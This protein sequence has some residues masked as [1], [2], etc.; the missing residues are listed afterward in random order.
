MDASDV[1]ARPD[2]WVPTLGNLGITA[3]ASELNKLDG[4]TVTT[5]EINYLDGVSS[6]IQTQLMVKFQQVEP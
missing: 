3:T 1:G 2:T 4:A 6:S 5:Q